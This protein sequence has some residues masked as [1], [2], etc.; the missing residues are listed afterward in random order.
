MRRAEERGTG[1]LLQK[2]ATPG[3][4]RGHSGIVGI[5]VGNPK[6]GANK[7]DVWLIG[8]STGYNSPHFAVY[9]PDLIEPCVLAGSSAKG[10]CADCGAPWKRMVGKIAQP[11]GFD[12]KNISQ[13]Q[14]GI[15]ESGAPLTVEGGLAVA[16]EPTHSFDVGFRGWEPNCECSGEIEPCVILDPF[17]GSGTTAGVALKHGRRAIL[18]ELH[19]EY[20]E[21]IPDRIRSIAEIAAVETDVE[22]V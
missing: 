10:C 1:I 21:L 14:F 12:W 2:S 17:G 3:D 7:R 8:P 4:E 15:D 20:A 6:I 13:T 22:W 5:P 16:I 18:C 9:P 19:A 11:I